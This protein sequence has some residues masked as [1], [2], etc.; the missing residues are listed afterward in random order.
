MVIVS[1]RA[2]S[3]SREWCLR[4]ASAA[5]TR[6]NLRGARNGQVSFE[7]GH[8]K[9]VGL[10]VVVAANRFGVCTL[11]R[12]PDQGEMIPVLLRHDRQLGADRQDGGGTRLLQER[13]DLLSEQSEAIT[14]LVGKPAAA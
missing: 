12:I 2:Q 3:H 10:L 11:G 6:E 1:D 8:A 4:G 5:S 14:T 9:C 7:P 13:T